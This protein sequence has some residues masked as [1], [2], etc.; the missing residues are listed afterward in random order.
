M[1]KLIIR[2]IALLGLATTYLVLP[3][4]WAGTL[5]SPAAPTDAGSA[6][7]STDDLYNRLQSG[8]PGV[9]RGGPFAEPTASPANQGKTLN[10]IMEAAP[11]S[12]NV[13]GAVP[14]EV[15]LGATYWSLR[16]DRS[17][18]L[19]AGTRT[20]AKVPRSGKTSEVGVPGEDG[21]LQKGVVWPK[22]RFTDNGNGTVTDNLTGLIWLRDADCF[23]GL[24]WNAALTAVSALNSGECGLNDGSAAGTW[25]LPQIAE[26]SSLVDYG[27]ANPAVPVD[28]S[29]P[30]PGHPFTDLRVGGDEW[31]WSSTTVVRDTSRA[32]CSILAIGNINYSPKT[33]THF[34][35]PVRG[36]Q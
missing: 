23:G 4:A 21:A 26:I 22:P 14:N 10:E 36:G 34:V 24:A 19:Q 25:R 13:T 18:G 27:R 2:D 6:M 1:K 28:P 30:A 16:T 15:T 7:V 9:K 8:A 17:W 5:N 20:P 3:A 31:Y 29:L 33:T 32:W 12:D 11:K 35:W